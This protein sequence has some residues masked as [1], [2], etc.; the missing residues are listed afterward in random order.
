MT[1]QSDIEQ[2]SFLEDCIS[3]KRKFRDIYEAID[4][5]S[6]TAETRK[7]PDFYKADANDLQK[8]IK[9]I[10]RTFRSSYGGD[11]DALRVELLKEDAF[12][13][14]VDELGQRYGSL[15]WG[16]A[17]NQSWRWGKQQM[18]SQNLRWENQANQK[19]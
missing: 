3:K 1:S 5:Y 13:N 15:I 4:L 8:K 11:E 10:A 12:V 6:E 19:L 7:D 2:T 17:A 16:R 9:E 14:E 18:R